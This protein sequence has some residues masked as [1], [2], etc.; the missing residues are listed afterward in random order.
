MAQDLLNMRV[1]ATVDQLLQY[2][3]QRRNMAQVLK[4]PFIVEP[5]PAME[6]VETN[7]ARSLASERTT[8]AHCYVQLRIIP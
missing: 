3:N 7:I 8:A 1:N 4:R 2:P 6:D 5:D